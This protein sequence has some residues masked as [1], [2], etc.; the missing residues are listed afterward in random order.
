M[1]D[2]KVVQP[3]LLF[4]EDGKRASHDRLVNEGE[5]NGHVYSSWQG[6]AHL[7]RA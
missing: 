4:K 6:R 2:W 7:T 3:R 1:T 5:K